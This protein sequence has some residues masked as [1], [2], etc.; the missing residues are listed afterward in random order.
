MERG[1]RGPFGG[2]GLSGDRGPLA[3]VGHET[4][5]GGP[6]RSRLGDGENKKE[7]DRALTREKRGI[8]LLKS[9]AVQFH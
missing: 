7:E 4:L 5:R 6:S 9:V 8:S 3:E 2:T 1:W